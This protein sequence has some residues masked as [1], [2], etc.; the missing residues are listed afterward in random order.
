M[1]SWEKRLGIMGCSFLIVDVDDD[2]DD[3]D[4]DNIELSLSTCVLGCG[5]LR[6]ESDTI[7]YL[8]A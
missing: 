6:V 8:T 2:D 5:K 7:Q 1:A 4:V 3:V